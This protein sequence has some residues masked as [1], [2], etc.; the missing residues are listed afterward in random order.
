M[1]IRGKEFFPAIAFL[2][3][4]V[5]VVLLFSSSTY[6]PYTKHEMFP[7]Y[8]TYEG[9]EEMEE[10]KKAKFEVPPP[11]DESA[12]GFEPVL[13][14]L[15]PGQTSENSVVL[16]KFTKITKNADIKDPKCYSA[17]LSN[18]KGALCLSPEL[19]DLLKT[20]GGNM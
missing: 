9:M 3:I 12:E 14:R 6:V 19:I 13:P 10:K 17:G 18:S 16:D 5:L 11:S 20:R 2:A 4:I 8:G 7:K 15:V 1:L